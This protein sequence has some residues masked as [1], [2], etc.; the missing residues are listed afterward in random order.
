M[1]TL[2]ARLQI[3]ELSPMIIRPLMVEL[4]VQDVDRQWLR[5]RLNEVVSYRLKG[6]FPEADEGVI[7]CVLEE[8]EK[9]SEVISRLTRLY[10]KQPSWNLSQNTIL[11]EDLLAG[12][13]A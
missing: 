7:D 13:A 5:N 8:G 6:L 11:N 9:L 1:A 10:P 3:T 4:G 2:I 12:L